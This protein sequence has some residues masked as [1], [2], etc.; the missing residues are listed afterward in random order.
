MGHLYCIYNMIIIQTRHTQALCYTSVLV[1][2]GILP[3]VMWPVLAFDPCKPGHTLPIKILMA[4][5]QHQTAEGKKSG[6]LKECIM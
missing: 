4:I 5:C 6:H 1:A 3:A 2:L